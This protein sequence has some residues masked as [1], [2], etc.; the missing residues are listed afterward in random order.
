MTDE[1]HQAVTLR[2]PFEVAP[3]RRFQEGDFAVLGHPATLTFRDPFH[4]ITV[5]K[6]PSDEDALRLLERVV[7]ALKWVAVETSDGIRVSR[8]VQKVA[9]REDGTLASFLGVEA[10][11]LGN[12]GMPAIYP[13][14]RI[15]R[16]AY[17]PPV[18]A[19]V[20]GTNE[21]FAQRLHQALAKRVDVAL[22]DKSLELAVDVLSG[23]YFEASPYAWFL[24]RITVLEILK[25]QADHPAPVRRLID[26]WKLT[27]KEAAEHGDVAPEIAQSLNSSLDRLRKQSIGQ[28]IGLLVERAT[29]SA[30]DVKKAK[31]LYN[32]RSKAVH[33]GE[34][35]LEEMISSLQELTEITRA[36]VSAAIEE[37]TGVES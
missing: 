35:D 19:E 8:D 7:G 4:V 27:L 28:A 22:D 21:M 10:H 6:I 31:S 12:E 24:G 16:F 30:E 33:D 23:T 3:G 9:Y 18:S 17:V 20:L 26:S 15:V 14:D 1:K 5:D 11:G 34:V 13:T 37:R 25:E 32:I 36:V 2:I 29:S